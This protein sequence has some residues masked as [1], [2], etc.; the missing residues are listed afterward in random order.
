MEDVY[1]AALAY[2]E[3]P[4]PLFRI[5]LAQLINSRSYRANVLSIWRSLSKLQLVKSI[6]EILPDAGRKLAQCPYRAGLKSERNKQL[7]IVRQ[8]IGVL[9]TCIHVSCM[10]VTVPSVMGGN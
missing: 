3:Y 6:S 9:V 8:I 2:I 1:R 7:A 10:S 5:L 4:V